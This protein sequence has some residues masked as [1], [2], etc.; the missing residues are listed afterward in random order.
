MKRLGGAFKTMPISPKD[1][2]PVTTGG[3]VVSES[4]NHGEVKPSPPTVFTFSNASLVSGE[5]SFKKLKRKKK[6]KQ[7][8]SRTYRLINISSIFVCNIGGDIK[9]EVT[10][11]SKSDVKPNIQLSKGL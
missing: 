11:D 2:K 6:H 3:V 1:M 5:L 7:L 10:A 9:Q 4:E 8:S